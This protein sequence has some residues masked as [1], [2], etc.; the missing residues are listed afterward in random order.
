MS[1]DSPQERW[2]S[3]TLGH[4]EDINAYVAKGL[5][6]GWD[7]AGK[8]PVAASYEDLLPAF[9]TALRAAN[10]QLQRKDIKAEWPPAYGP[11]HPLLESNGQNIST[12][13]LLP[14]GSLLARIGAPYEAG[15]IV[16]I[17]GDVVTHVEGVQHIGRCPRR[18][19]FAVGREQ[20]VE[21]T[22]G[23]LGERVA[24]CP[25]PLGTEGVPEG[26]AVTQLEKPP[27]PTQLLPFP[28]GTRVLLVSS[29][30]IFVLR[31]DGAVRLLPTQKEM[32]EH[33]SWLMEECPEDDLAV[34]LSMEHG[35]ISADG[36]LIAVGAQDGRH[37]VFNAAL[38]CIAEIGPHGEYPHYAAFS[39]DQ[40]VLA[41]NACH[42]Y[43]GT[44][45]GIDIEKIPGL[46]SDF[47]DEVE[48]LKILEKGARVY[49]AVARNNEFI[50]GDA[51]G[52]LRAT[53]LAG[54]CRWQHYIGSTVGAMDLSDDGKTLVAST[55]AGFISIIDLDAGR[56]QPYQIGNG[57]HF[58]RRRWVFWKGE[59]SPL[60]W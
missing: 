9:L 47:Y 57:G 54:N 16:H 39:A 32:R 6:E 23:W 11:L 1:T 30:G 17:R 59:S 49:A 31:D 26:F 22:D 33:F 46:D 34:G 7:R 60:A 43:N 45:I 14:D 8:E 44:T 58:E 20:G 48:G 2:R 4:A 15:R 21:V 38:Q 41:L 28:D 55:C 25:W 42:F 36:S 40:Q 18:R 29:D 52:Y 5:A 51:Y 10:G 50:F 27:V 3:L 12:L 19:Y 35:A 53:D 56:Q 24:L 37:R 13:Y